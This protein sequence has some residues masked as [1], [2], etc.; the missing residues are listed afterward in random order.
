MFG[1]KNS[2]K[3]KSFSAATEHGIQKRVNQFGKKH[4]IINVSISSKSPAL[5]YAALVTYKN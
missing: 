5:G 3:V 1:Q 4:E 2:T